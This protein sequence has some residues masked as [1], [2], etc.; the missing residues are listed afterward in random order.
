MEKFIEDSFEYLYN[1]PIGNV[2]DGNRP[3]F[4]Y[5]Y[6][7][8]EKDV[9]NWS[10]GVIRCNIGS[11]DDFIYSIE[12]FRGSEFKTVDESVLPKI[13]EICKTLDSLKF[14]ENTKFSLRCK[15]SINKNVTSFNGV[16]ELYENHTPKAITLID[17][18]LIGSNHGITYFS[19]DSISRADIITSI[20]EWGAYIGLKK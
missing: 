2:A 20:Y 18:A 16:I 9:L 7:K 17:S 4:N 10:N 5:T 8:F 6:Y 14:D 19:N 15:F 13:K 12:D 1:N 11:L 3:Y